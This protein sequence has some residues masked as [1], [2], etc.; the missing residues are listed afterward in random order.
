[1]PHPQLM[2]RRTVRRL[3]L[4][5]VTPPPQLPQLSALTSSNPNFQT[6][7]SQIQNQLVS[8]GATTTQFQAAQLALVNSWTQLTSTQFGV[9]ADQALKTATQYAMT[10]QTAFGAAQMV[11]SLVSA[12]QSGKPPSPA[13]I[14]SFTGTLIGT[15]ETVGVLSSGVGAVIVAAVAIGLSVLE[16]VAGALFGKAPTGTTVAG[17]S[18]MGASG[19]WT[20]N[21]CSGIVVD[22]VPGW[23]VGC[24]AVWGTDGTAGT[25]ISTEPSSPDWRSFPDPTDASDSWWFQPHNG[26]PSTSWAGAQWATTWGV[27]RQIDFA[28]PQYGWLECDA[29]NAPANLLPFV[30][31][32]ISA[33]KA[34]AAYALNGLQPASDAS[35]LA[36]VILLW[37]RANP[38]GAPYTLA[39]VPALPSGAVLGPPGGTCPTNLPADLYASQLVQYLIQNP[40]TGLSVS[41]AGVVING[42]DAV[43]NVPAAV[44]SVPVTVGSQAPASSA[45]TS[46]AIGTATAAAVAAGGLA[47]YAYT[48]RQSFTGLLRSLWA[49]AKGVL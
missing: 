10:A 29:A 41:A 23:A 3:G 19:A 46:V 16:A 31:A 27:G 13:L 32:F 6:S 47:V 5:A 11:S 43:P 2:P 21:T 42:P 12:M 35:V 20:A 38:N 15:L 33:W 22:P 34:N 45:L 26:G 8:E 17:V 39:P 1:M 28:F 7:W 18:P 49:G 14:K 30:H 44:S 36:Q 24:M 37:N 48:S 40:P 4:G 25:W 9:D